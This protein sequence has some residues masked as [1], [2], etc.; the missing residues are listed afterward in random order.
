MY[1]Q[2]ENRKRISN[3]ISDLFPFYLELSLDLRILRVGASMQK[4]ARDITINQTIEFFFSIKKPKTVTLSFF[5]EQSIGLNSVLLKHLKSDFLFR[6]QV[7]RDQNEDQLFLLCSPAISNFLK[8][9]EDYNLKISDYAFYDTMPDFLFAMQ[10]QESSIHE[11]KSLN[12]H[13]KEQRK[14]L[15]SMNQELEN[16]VSIA[17]HDLQTPLRSIVGFSQLIQ[18]NLQKGKIVELEEFSELIIVSG[19]RMKQVLDDLLAYSSLKTNTKAKT[20]ISLDAIL[21]EVKEILCS[22]IESSNAIIEHR[23][24]PNL[25][26]HGNQMRQL[27]M[28]L[29]SNAIKFSKANQSPKIN[30]NW[31]QKADCILFEVK[32]NGIGI[33]AQYQDRIFKLF[34]RLHKTSEYEGTGIGLAIC[35]KIVEQH[36]GKIWFESKLNHGSSF[37]FTIKITKHLHS[38]TYSGQ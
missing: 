34:Q 17:S 32:D 37:F 22:D 36:S 31:T 7:Y 14:E 35:K 9:E 2:T 20:E 19:L 24:L 10:A 33:E 4:I 28:N 25:V 13:L 26:A 3:T 38:S 8:N 29:L 30:V 5:L 12:Q 1:S 27:F 18:R 6:A 15:L 23:A 16:Y 11:I 21:K